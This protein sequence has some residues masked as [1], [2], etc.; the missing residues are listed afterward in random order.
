MGSVPPGRGGKYQKTP[1]IEDKLLRGIQSLDQ[2][3]AAE[4]ITDQHQ[5]QEETR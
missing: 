5:R 1:N 4:A 3:I 2:Q